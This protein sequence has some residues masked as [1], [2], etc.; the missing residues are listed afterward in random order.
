MM[1]M[2]MQYKCATQLQL[3]SVTKVGNKMFL[4]SF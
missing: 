1:P 3:N 2:L 4:K